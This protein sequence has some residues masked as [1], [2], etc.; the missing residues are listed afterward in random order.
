LISKCNITDIHVYDIKEGQAVK[1]LILRTQPG[2]I[3]EDKEG[4]E[5]HYGMLLSIHNYR[6]FL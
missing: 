3:W 4:G 5:Y 6:T 1:Y 2:T